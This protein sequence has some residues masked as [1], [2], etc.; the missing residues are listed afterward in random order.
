[1]RRL[2][3]GPP[4]RTLSDAERSINRR[5]HPERKPPMRPRHLPFVR[6]ALPVFAVVTAA[7]AAADD[8]LPSWND[9]PSKAAIVRFVGEV[10]RQGGRRFVPVEERIAVFD[11]DGTLWSEQPYYNQVAFAFD[12]IKALAPGYPEWKVKPAFR[13]VL[14]GDVKAILAG[15]PRDRLEL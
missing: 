1:R 13:A 10:T 5:S 2:T 7:G 14:E 11:N 8:L 4:E 3:R 6:I 15:T 12:R 9:G